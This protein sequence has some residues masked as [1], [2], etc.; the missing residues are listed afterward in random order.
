ML[1]TIL[2]C[3]GAAWYIVHVGGQMSVCAQSV[4]IVSCILLYEL[5]SALCSD[6]F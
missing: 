6:M 2:V 1:L 3:L 4:S 5:C